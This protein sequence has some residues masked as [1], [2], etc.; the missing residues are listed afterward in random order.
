MRPPLRFANGTARDHLTAWWYCTT[1][2]SRLLPQHHPGR[3]RWPCRCRSLAN[4]TTRE[5]GLPHARSVLM[6][7]NNAITAVATGSGAVAR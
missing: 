2:C 6:L 3:L 4:G 5:H 1:H 7:S